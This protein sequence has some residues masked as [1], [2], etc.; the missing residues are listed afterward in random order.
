MP[1]GKKKSV[2]CVHLY[3][4]LRSNEINALCFLYID[5]ITSLFSQIAIS[6]QLCCFL[7]RSQEEKKKSTDTF[8]IS[9]NARN[10]ISVEIL[11]SDVIAF[12]SLK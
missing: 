3:A 9:N 5:P 12:L 7:I 11:F 2:A 10:M 8:L 1:W 6:L 4:S